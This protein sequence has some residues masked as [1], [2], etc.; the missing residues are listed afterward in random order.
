MFPRKQTGSSAHYVFKV[1]G[2][3]EIVLPILAKEDNFYDF[4]SDSRCAETILER[5]LLLKKKRLIEEPISPHRVDLGN[6]F[7]HKRASLKT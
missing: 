5:I 4:L 2:C 3:S 6:K 7:I 1:C